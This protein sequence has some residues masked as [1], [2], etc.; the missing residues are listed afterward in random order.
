M[1]DKKLK[2]TQ[3][4]IANTAK[5]RRIKAAQAKQEQQKKPVKKK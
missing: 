1:T 3:V 5:G 4:A 2:R